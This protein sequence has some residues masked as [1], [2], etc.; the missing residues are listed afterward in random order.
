[1]TCAIVVAV[2][3]PW[4]WV[5]RFATTLPVGSMRICAV[6]PVIGCI[7]PAEPVGSI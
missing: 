5:E 3:C 2:P 6:S 1:M 7:E 4:L